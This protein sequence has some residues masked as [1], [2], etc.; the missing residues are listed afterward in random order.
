MAKVI[1]AL[2]SH[3]AP[4]LSSQ[5]DAIERGLSLAMENTGQ[6]VFRANIRTFFGLV[7][8]FW[9]IKQIQYREAAIYMKSG[10]LVMLARFFSNHHNFWTGD[11]EKTLFVEASLRR[12]IASFPIGDPNVMR[13]AGSGGKSRFILYSMLVDHVNSGKRTRRLTARPGAIVDPGED[14][15]EE[16]NGSE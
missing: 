14:G 6:N 7:D 1:G 15:G 5:L 13:L 4:A 8:E 12:K 11:G 3:K 9:G 16:T 10:F 2:H